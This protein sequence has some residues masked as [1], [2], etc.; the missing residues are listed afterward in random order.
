MPT[1]TAPSSVLSVVLYWMKLAGPATIWPVAGARARSE[2]EPEPSATLPSML[3]ALSRPSASALT[4]V[5]V[6][7]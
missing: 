1:E 6:A 5:A 2:T 3:A 7:W 4:P